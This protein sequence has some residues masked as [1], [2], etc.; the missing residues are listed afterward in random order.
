[1]EIQNKILKWSIII[2]GVIA[3]GELVYIVVDK[4]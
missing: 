4:I 3:G 1:M 2:I